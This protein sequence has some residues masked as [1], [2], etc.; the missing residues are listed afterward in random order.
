M[1]S[2]SAASVTG[3]DTLRR[4]W[5]VVLA[6]TVAAAV[7]IN[8]F[9]PAYNSLQTAPSAAAFQHTLT[10]HGR[11]IAAT[12]C[13]IVFALGYGALGLI[14]LRTLDTPRRLAR[15]AAVLIIASALCDELENIVLV[16]NIVAARTLTDGWIT[17]MRG[18]G[19]LKWIGLPIFF[20]LLVALALRAV[21]RD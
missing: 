11:A 14:A 7:G 3:I 6:I 13:D 10:D 19:A 16:R 9:E 12:G 8:L 17:V 5:I 15:P 21:R 20:V 1:D 18:P 4:R 2:A